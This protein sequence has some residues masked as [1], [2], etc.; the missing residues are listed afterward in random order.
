M[1]NANERLNVAF[2]SDHH[3]YYMGH[4]FLEK[5]F[6]SQQELDNYIKELKKTYPN[7]IHT[8]QASTD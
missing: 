7:L 3:S 6:D 4:F 5:I 1:K 2:Y 8:L